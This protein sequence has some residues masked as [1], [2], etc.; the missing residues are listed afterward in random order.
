MNRYKALFGLLACAYLSSTAQA[1]TIANG[2]FENFSGTVSSSGTLLTSGNASLTGWSIVS[3]VGILVEPNIYNLT[4]SDGV[5]FLDLTSFSS[6]GGGSGQGI[7]QVLTGL[8]IGQIYSVSM[9]LGV[10]NLPCVSGGINCTG[11]ITVQA[12]ADSTTATFSHNSALPGNVWNNFSF[13]F[14]ANSTSAPLRITMLSTP[15]YYVGLDNVSISAVPE[16]NVAA[17]FCMGLLVVG[18]ARTKF[19]HCADDRH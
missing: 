18:I 14:T 13:M 3:Q 6:S 1:A 5:N 8:E 16:G 10:S 15:G 12:S 2:S 9:D 4:A 19:K 11:P 17:L 7:E